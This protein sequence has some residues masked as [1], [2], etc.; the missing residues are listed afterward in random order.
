MK[1]VSYAEY[2]SFLGNHTYTY[3]HEY[4]VNHTTNVLLN[5]KVV[6]Q[7]V[8]TDNEDLYFIEK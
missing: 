2:Y 5:G 4:Y 7:V 3:K 8:R 1:Q 6:A